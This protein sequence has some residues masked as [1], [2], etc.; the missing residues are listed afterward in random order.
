[1]H[2]E[3]FPTLVRGLGTIGPELRLASGDIDPATLQRF[4]TD[5]Q[6]DAYFTAADGVIPTACVD[7]R[8]P[9]QAEAKR[10][11]KSAAGTFSVVV[12]DALTRGRFLQADETAADHARHVYAYLRDNE[13][14]VGG[15]DA[16]HASET[17]CGCG[18]ED[19][20]DRIFGFMADYGEDVREALSSLGVQINNGIHQSIMERIADRKQQ[21]YTGATGKALRQAYVDTAG[22]ASVETLD[23]PHNE[24]CVV[25]NTKDGTLDRAQLRAAYGDQ[26][27]A[28]DV[29]LPALRKTSEIV[30]ETDDEAE[31][32][33]IAMLYYN[34]ATAAVLSHASLCV[35]VR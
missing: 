35:V 18:A 10:T 22:E 25:I 14:Q 15:H 21:G 20:L 30:A 13:F 5:L 33:Y 8:M 26:Y 9:A 3:T 23:G 19:N 4:Y 17:G 16:T 24:V 2:E 7:G 12:G 31:Q 1:M 11:P 34:Y 29:D 28:F 32:M 27:E 6:G